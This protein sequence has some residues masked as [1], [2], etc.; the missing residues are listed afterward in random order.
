MPGDGT[1]DVTSIL[2]HRLSTA[3]SARRRLGAASAATI[4]VLTAAGLLLDQSGTAQAATAIG[5]GTADSFAV[6]AYAGITNTGTTVIT[7]DIG[8]ETSTI[9]T[10]ISVTGAQNPA[11]T[12]DAKHDMDTAYDNAA[13]QTPAQSVGT[14]LGGTELTPGVYSSPTFGLTGA[15]T[16][17]AGGDADAVFVLQAG[18]TLITASNS[19]VVL[20]GGAQ[21]CNVYWQVG[22]S[23]TLA[24]NSDF[25]GN[26]LAL[27]SVTLNTGAKVT[28][29]VFARNAS[30]TLDN[31]VITRPACTTPS[32]GG[33]GG[34]SGNGGSGSG[35]SGTNGAGTDGAHQVA[36]VPVGSVDAG[37]GSS[38]LGRSPHAGE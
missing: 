33:S 21:A 17:N 14:E 15:L 9:D 13:G 20:T 29:R 10:G 1:T 31:N 38:L 11:G 30:V 37:D 6:L 27:A 4:A 36:Q 2:D 25:A 18:S 26:V 28:G 8:T 19:S 34:D 32:G 7:G 3:P 22:S 12:L 5:L 16:L 23:A 24:T 35:G